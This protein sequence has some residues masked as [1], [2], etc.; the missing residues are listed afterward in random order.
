MSRRITGLLLAV[1]AVLMAA[2]RLQAQAPAAADVDVAT[3]PVEIDGH[4]LFRL[5]G[6]SSFPAGE[7]ARLVTDRIVAAAANP[8]ASVDRL[9]VVESDVAAEV[10]LGDEPLLRIFDADAALEQV[11]RAELAGAHMVRVRQAIVDYRAARTRDARLGNGITSLVATL[12]LALGIGLVVWLWRRLDV[13]MVA[14]MERHV[15]TVGIQSF[16]VVRA[17][18]IRAALRN[19]VLGLRTFVILVGIL[20]YVGYLLAVWPATR[21]LSRDIVGFALSP[22]DVIGQGIVRN[23]P[24]LVF[25]VVLFF[26]IRLVLRLVRLFFETVGRGTVKLANFDA[27]WAEPT[28]KIARIAII[29]FGLIVAYPYI[30]GSESDAFKGVSLFIGIVFSLGSSSAISNIIAGYMMTYRRAF[31]VGDRVKIGDAMGDVIEM[32]LQVTH[33]KTFK[34]EEIVIP[35][36]QILS[37]DVINYS[38]FAKTQG[39]IL[40]TEVGIGYETPWRQVEAM[41]LE[42]AGRCQL[43][44]GEP[45]RAFVRL[46]KLADFA[47]TYEANVYCTDITAMLPMYGALHRHILDVFNEYGVQIMTPAYEGDP[48]QPKIVPPKDWFTAPAVAPASPTPGLRVP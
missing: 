9:R 16:E 3:A 45:P 47:V 12:A 33:L 42:A 36:S 1:V 20:V 40:Y 22:L 29:A 14:R 17:D 13:L 18:Q 44:S 4:V 27:D 19:G 8:A 34:N 2:G 21:G 30:P 26:V 25:L 10:A 5:R 41:L 38:S 23:V 24:S 28:Y 35:N 7:R 6:V 39:L 31:K 46:K 43:P 32:R 37:G 11:R 15:Q 48:E